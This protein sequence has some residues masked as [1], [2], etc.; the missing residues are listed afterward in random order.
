MIV[1]EPQSV[2]GGEDGVGAK[3]IRGL[4]P[5]AVLRYSATHLRKVHEVYRLDAV[6]AFQRRLVKRI[7][8]AAAVAKAAHNKPYVKLVKVQTR[9]AAARGRRWSW[10]WRGRGVASGES[11]KILTGN[12][13]LEQ[14]T[15]RDVY[16]DVRLGEIRGGK[17]A[18]QTGRATGRRARRGLASAWRN[19]R[20]DRPEQ[21]HRE[22]IERAV[23]AHLDKELIRRPMG[24]KVLSLFFLDSVGDYREYG[25]ERQPDTGPVD[26]VREDLPTRKKQDP[27]YQTLFEGIP[28]DGGGGGARR[29]LRPRQGQDGREGRGLY[30][31]FPPNSG[32]PQSSEAPRGEK[33]AYDLIM[34]AKEGLLGLRTSR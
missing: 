28:R 30:D 14:T 11:E 29:V 17:A 22:L 10:R 27:K 3:A 31:D 23:T 9:R 8:V 34:E 18:E 26:D 2:E 13:N 1:D 5:L 16:R 24:I 15:G 21:L 33:E 32:K 6:D 19:A 4:N 12:E 20:R 25:R 7:E